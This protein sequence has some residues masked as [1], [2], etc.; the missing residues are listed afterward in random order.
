MSQMSLHKIYSI[1]DYSKVNNAFIKNKGIQ[2]TKTK[3]K[4]LLIKENKNFH[5]RIHKNTNYVVFGDLDNF[6]YNFEKFIEI[7]KKF[8]NEKYN[9]KISSNDIMYTK[10]DSKSGSFHYSIPKYYGK[11]ETLHLI[12]TTFK[13]YYVKNLENVK[14]T[15]IDTTIYS[16]HWYRCPNQGK[17]S[18]SGNDTHIIIR[19]NMVDFIVDYIPKNSLCI[20]DIVNKNT[21]NK[22][23]KKNEKQLKNK[24]ENIEIVELDTKQVSLEKYKNL[25]NNSENILSSAISKPV[26]CKK[27]FDNCYKPERFDE[28]NTWI[29]VGMAIK[30][31]FLDENVALD[32]FNYFSSKGSK[33]EGIEKTNCKYATFVKKEKSDGYTI[34]T[35]YHIAVEDNKAK[36]IEIMSKN[37]LELEPTDMC[38]FLKTIAGYKFIYKKENDKYILYSYNGKYWENDDILF[39]KCLSNELYEFLKSILIEVYWN[40]SEFKK[41]KGKIDKLKSISLKKEILDT[42]KE[43]GVN[44]D[45]VMDDKWWLLGFN[46]LVYDLKEDKMR[47]Y[48]YDDYICTTTGY[49]WREP[50]QEELDTMNSII[51]TVMPLDDEREFYLKLLSTCLDGKALEKF[52]V[53]NGRG[54]NGKGMINDMLL[55]ALGNYAIIGNNGILFESSKSGTNPEKAIIH[56]KRLVIFREPSEKFKFDNGV[57]KELTGGGTIS[58][59]D[60]YENKNKIKKELNLTLIVEC[61]KRPLFSEEPGDAEVRRLLDINFRSSFVSNNDMIDE[62]NHIFK[63]NPEYK[64]SEFQNKY[65]YALMKILMNAYKK[66]KEDGSILIPPE[67]I[68]KRTDK[69]LQMSCNLLGWFKDNYEKCEGQNLKLLDVYVNF[70]SSDFYLEGPKSLKD[71]YKKKYFLEYFENNIFTR[72]DY[73]ERTNS[74][75]HI[76]K[77]WKQ[78][79]INE[80]DNN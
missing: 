76:L 62:E 31:T 68:K 40:A 29:T 7:F 21:K 57:I 80:E 20:D 23:Q 5:F 28:Y 65:K 44:N 66:Y 3:L 54:G 13:D 18:G 39:K 2:L 69:Y 42:Y 77:N 4:N 79:E 32:L 73:V 26:I 64:T 25:N 9:L 37:T 47:E 51:K 58:A 12:H 11:T 78:K 34:A 61:N 60:L 33:Y 24:N 17:G 50:T 74:T 27:I 49:N 41:L 52:I 6:S 30:N 15:N 56:K 19:G 16:E 45:I 22:K 35:I 67:T 63:A 46:N 38:R 10:N 43:Y 72:R 59:R 71:K 53:F 55:L 1:T 70:K 8:F 36:F 14:E 75:R 48:K